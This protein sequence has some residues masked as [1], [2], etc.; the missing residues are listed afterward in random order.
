M[1]V[2]NCLPLRP[3][4][5]CKGKVQL[6]KHPLPEMVLA[7][8][9]LGTP[10]GSIGHTVAVRI[11]LASNGHE[12]KDSNLAYTHRY[13]HKGRRIRRPYFEG[14]THGGPAASLTSSS[15]SLDSYQKGLRSCSTHIRTSKAGALPGCCSFVPIGRTPAHPRR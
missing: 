2:V 13:P 1:F 11:L 10:G 4:P 12:Q 14:Q 8:V 5:Y 7:Q 3:A 15:R 9:C 6:E